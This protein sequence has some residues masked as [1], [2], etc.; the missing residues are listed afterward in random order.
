MANS[1]C[2][3]QGL[4]LSSLKFMREARRIGMG[5]AVEGIGLAA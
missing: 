2:C 5:L 1:S 3:R 4:S